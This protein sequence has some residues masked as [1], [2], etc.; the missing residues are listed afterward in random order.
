MTRLW[1]IR[2]IR[3]VW[4]GYWYVRAARAWWHMGLGIGV[5]TEQDIARLKGIWKGTW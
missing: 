1:G 5:P 3:Y 2:H 4:H